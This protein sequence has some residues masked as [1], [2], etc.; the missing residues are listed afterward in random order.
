M[1]L[2]A[3]DDE[4][5]RTL[6][7][8]VRLFALDQIAAAWWTSTPAGRTNARRRL[9]TL[10]DA[11]MLRRLRVNVRPL[12]ALEGPVLSWQPGD[13]DPPFGA[14]AWRLQSRWQ[15]PPRTTTVYIATRRGA[16]QYGGRQRGELRREFQATHDLGVAA[17][18]LRMRA[19]DSSR[20]EGWIG[21][22]VLAPHRRG[23]KLPDAVLADAP[24][25]PPRLVL[26]FG[27]A[28]D[29]DRVRAFHESCAEDELPYQL[30]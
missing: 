21:E 20:V 27:G 18:F 22:D 17:M 26:E 11:G 28:Y 5:L 4:I 14:V 19:I 3:R 23:Q 16:N 24:D 10:V 12:P 2:V 7:L 30:W 15:E 8:R 13:A 25:R 6:S 1:L 29:S 9:A